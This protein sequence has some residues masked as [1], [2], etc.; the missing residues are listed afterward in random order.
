[1]PPSSA[2]RA[3]EAAQPVDAFG[4]EA[5]GGLVEDQHLAAGRAARRP[6]RAAGACRAS[7]VLTRRSAASARP[8]CSSTSSTRGDRQ[9][10]RRGQHAQVVACAPA[11][12]EA[13]RLEHGADLVRGSSRSPYGVPADRGGA[14]GR[15]D[16]AEQHAQRRRLAGAV[17][18]E[19]AGDGALACDE[20]QA[21]DGGDV[22]VS[23]WTVR[24]ISMVDMPSS[25]PAV[26]GAFRRPRGR[27]ASAAGRRLRR[28]RDVHPCGGGRARVRWTHA[29]AWTACDG[30]GGAE[31]RRGRLRPIAVVLA[32]TAARSSLSATIELLGQDPAFEDPARLGI[33]V[34]AAGGD[35]AAGAAPPLPADGRRGR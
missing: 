19:E 23:A 32:V 25:V 28:R 11:R 35:A 7:S 12:V 29:G 8:T 9:T 21:V 22:T 13:G 1:M 31:P 24:W 2:N 5:V 20:A 18:A 16:E 34:G 3:Q 30:V 33:V 6:G 27:F 15:C 10:G 4:I 14:A 17:R 26:R